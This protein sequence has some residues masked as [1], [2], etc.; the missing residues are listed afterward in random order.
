M[1]CE[2]MESLSPDERNLVQLYLDGYSYAEIGA[3]LGILTVSARVRMNRLV[4]RM[5]GIATK[6][7]LTNEINI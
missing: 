7:G 2:V 3:E 4:K 6:E 1:T 5:Q